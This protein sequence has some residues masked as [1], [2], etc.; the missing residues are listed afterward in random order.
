[1]NCSLL[2]VIYFIAFVS[3]VQ[4]LNNR[5]IIGIVAQSTKGT[6][7]KALG[8]SYIDAAYVKYIESSGARVVPINTG[9]TDKEVVNIFQS[10]NGVLFP[11][12]DVSVTNSD[13]ARIGNIIYN[14]AMTAFDN[15]DYF[16]L[17]G[18][19]LGFELLNVMVSGSSSVLSPS[20]SENLPLP[21]DFTPDYRESKMF[22][23]ISPRLAKYLSTAPTTIN[24]HHNCVT[25]KT[26]TKEKKLRDFF[27]VLSTNIGRKGTKFV[28]TMEGNKYPFYGSQWH[29]E[30]NPFEWT[31][32]LNIPHYAMSIEVT[33]YMSNF[34]VNQTR[35]NRHKFKSIE[36]EQTHLI[37]NYSPVYTGNISNW[38]L[39]YIFH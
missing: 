29:P 6:P 24:L 31:T 32:A 18:I 35:L 3:R 1:M 39:T 38:E 10:I 19:C 37:Y 26:F 15:N 16:P 28:S 25:S 9:L 5:P 12:G 14:Q 22:A 36:E 30:K 20:D 7:V 33:Q 23:N 8:K 4:T 13:Y 11:G 27:R 2:L 34:F 21:L 17:W